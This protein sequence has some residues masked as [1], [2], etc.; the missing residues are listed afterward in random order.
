[1]ST[2]FYG[3]PKYAFY[4]NDKVHLG[5]SAIG[6][7]FQ[8]RAHSDETP[9]VNDIQSWLRQLGAFDR[10]E[11]EYRRKYTVDEFLELVEDRCNH[12]KRSGGA[13]HLKS[14]LLVLKDS[15]R[16]LGDWHR[17]RLFVS[18]QCVF[19]DYEFS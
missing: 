5:Q 9:P 7:E 3:V 6:W 17:Q 2:N 18:E 12:V 11:D 4:A 14:R 10:I 15:G 1:M 19:A 13:R 16:G 8:F